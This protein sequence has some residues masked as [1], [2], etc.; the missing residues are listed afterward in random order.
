MLD[1]L[2]DAH[3]GEEPSG[4]TSNILKQVASSLRPFAIA[5]GDFFMRALA[6]MFC[7]VA[8]ASCSRATG[9]SPLPGAQTGATMPLAASLAHGSTDAGYKSLY[10]F[11]GGADGQQPNGPFIDVNGALFGTTLAGG[12]LC[13]QGVSQGISC[14]TVFRVRP[15][16]RENVLYRFK[17][18][19]SDGALPQQGLVTLNG[20]LYGVT[21]FGGD[22]GSG[23]G[24][25]DLGCGTIFK[26][27]LSGNERILYSFKGG[28]TDGWYP[29]GGLFAMN[30]TLY[31]TTSN[32]G[33]LSCPGNS[34]C[35]TIFV[36]SISGV[37]K[38]LY[39]FK[40][41]TERAS[42]ERVNGP[43]RRTLWNDSL[44]WRIGLR[45]GRMRNR[46]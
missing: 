38:V 40:G 2:L 33:G 19:T 42:S 10:S 17:G 43:E 27:S 32:G 39:D 45:R 7:G 13:P 11:Q 46:F 1:S 30:G 8:L 31:G 18:G 24:C 9:T 22:G 6:L 29:E 4:E 3:Y 25:N 14:G 5:L 44:R 15:S 35:G 34:G 23:S 21:V 37:E 36:V 41:G 26:V 20:E 28:T 12:E 16:G